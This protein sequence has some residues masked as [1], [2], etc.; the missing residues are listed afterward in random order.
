MVAASDV[1]Y[2]TGEQVI[3]PAYPHVYWHELGGET[4]ASAAYA[5]QCGPLEHAHLAFRRTWTAL[6]GNDGNCLVWRYGIEPISREE[7]EE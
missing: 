3:D 5:V 6:H 4:P 7:A 2:A 1:M